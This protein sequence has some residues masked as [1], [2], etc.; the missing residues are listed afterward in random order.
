MAVRKVGVEEELMLVD[1]VSG[2][3]LPVASATLAAH[4]D[5]VGEDSEESGDFGPA[6]AWGPSCSDSRSRPVRHHAARP[7]S[8]GVTW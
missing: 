6:P 3:V 7:T 5:R 4:R 1:S 8:S 2:V